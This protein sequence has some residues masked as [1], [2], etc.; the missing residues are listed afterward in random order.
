MNDMKLLLAGIHDCPCG[1][2]HSSPIDFVE[3]GSGAL[4]TLPELCKSYKSILLVADRNTYAV[5]GKTV[6]QL[7]AASITAKLVYDSGDGVVIPD[8][9]S[10][11]QMEAVL[12][13]DT[14]LILGVGS[15]VINDLCKYVSFFHDLPYYIVATAP[16]M[17][18]YASTGA[19]MILKG[20][21]E[22]VSARCPKAIVADTAVLKDAPFEMLQA[23]YGDIVGKYSCLNDWKLSA[24]LRDEYFCQKV[25]DITY[26]EADRVKALAQG[27]VNRDEEA[28]GAL[29]EALVIVGIAMAYVGNSRPASGSEHHLSHYFEITG[30]LNN[31][32][33]LCHGIDVLYSAVVTA[34]V[35]EKLVASQ[36]GSFSFDRE[37]WETIIRKLY[38]ASADE[39][40]KLQ[41]KMG[42][43]QEDDCQTV[44]DRWE[45]AR[46]LLAEAPTEQ[47]MLDMV[48]AVGLNYADFVNLYGRQKIEDAIL[49]A[50]DLKDRYSVLW[51][52]YKYFGG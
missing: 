46:Q 15:G 47:E 21:K 7:L 1:K 25:Y 33:Y 44:H 23:G 38:T 20:M 32:P 5:C 24:L 35:R 48:N 27:V 6:E 42:W 52:A 50:K 17:D 2:D 14:D 31:E 16:S 41:D 43:Y 36:P 12:R 40:I 11:A 10:I 29:M 30:I 26:Q 8:E 49:Y 45:A 22:T 13:E 19:A 4:N 18:G 34:A 51:L 9:Q 39:V 37:A 28:V 3:I